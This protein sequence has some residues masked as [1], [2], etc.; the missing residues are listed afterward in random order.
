MMSP[1]AKRSN[2]LFDATCV[3]GVID[4]PGTQDQTGLNALARIHLG[5][6]DLMRRI[7]AEHGIT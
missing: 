3:R 1:I 7:K 5:I 6:T 2:L 4:D